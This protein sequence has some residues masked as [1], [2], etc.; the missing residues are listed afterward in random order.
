MNETTLSPNTNNKPD[1][2]IT[3]LQ[4]YWKYKV[5]QL[6]EEHPDT[7]AALDKLARECLAKGRY[8]EAESFLRQAL[9]LREKQLAESDPDLVA[10]VI[11]L[12]TVLAKQNKLT[13]AESLWMRAWETGEYLLG[14]DHPLTES[15]SEKLQ[16]LRQLNQSQ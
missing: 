16:L 15:A 5:A 13:E 6:G 11:Q 9:Q 10:T 8:A 14:K 4:K 3:R 12:G 7:L 2:E 1:D